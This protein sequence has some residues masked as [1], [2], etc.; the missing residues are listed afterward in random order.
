VSDRFRVVEYVT[1]LSTALEE[2]V[3]FDDVVLI[4]AATRRSGG[5]NAESLYQ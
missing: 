5:G 4:S 3:P 2:L 1:G